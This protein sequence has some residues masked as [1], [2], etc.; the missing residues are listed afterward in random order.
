MMKLSIHQRGVVW[1][2]VP[3]L[4]SGEEYESGLNVSS[5]MKTSLMPHL[6]AGCCDMAQLV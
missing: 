1:I 3:L 4:G 2:A 6:F 5:R